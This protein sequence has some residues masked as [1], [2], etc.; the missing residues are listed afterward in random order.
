MRC[1]LRALGE[2]TRNSMRKTQPL[3]AEAKNKPSRREAALLSMKGGLGEMLCYTPDFPQGALKGD[4]DSFF[5]FL[6]E[7]FFCFSLTGLCAAL[8]VS[9][10][11]KA[12]GSTTGLLCCFHAARRVVF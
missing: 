6:F 9:S 10:S 7:V 8:I 2:A 1:V 12:W 3:A 4:R 11:R 5:F